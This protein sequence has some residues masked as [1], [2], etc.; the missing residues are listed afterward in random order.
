MF[1]YALFTGSGFYAILIP[2]ETTHKNGFILK[3]IHLYEKGV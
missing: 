3:T 2:P 1:F